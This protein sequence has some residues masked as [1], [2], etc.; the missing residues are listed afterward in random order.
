MARV[1]LWFDK[2]YYKFYLGYTGQGS[3][4]KG[5]GSEF[6]REY[7]KRPNDFKCR[8]LKFG[9][10]EKMAELEKVLLEKRKHQFGKRYYNKI[11]H[12]PPEDHS[13]E[14]KKIISEAK[15]KNWQDKNYRLEKEKSNFKSG[16][17]NPNYNKKFTS[18]ELKN[19]S[20]TAKKNYSVIHSEESRRKRS[21]AQKGRKLITVNGVRRWSK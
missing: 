20:D 16:K 8:N 5:S 21:E 15:K 9:T 12:W 7:N 19:L 11:I 6:K 18:E 3:L 13:I 14:T 4:Y 17:N 10:K 2:L 1:Y